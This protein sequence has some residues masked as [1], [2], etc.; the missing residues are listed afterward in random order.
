M[1]LITTLQTD[2]LALEKSDFVKGAI[3]AVLV[4][5]GTGLAP[6][7]QSG[8]FPTWPQDLNALYAGLTAGGM[9]L[10]KNLLTDAQGKF[11]GINTVTPVATVLPPAPPK[12]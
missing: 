1:T 11:L 2:F 12:V 6:I 8:A 7:L 9:Y 3:L 5:I 4:S 10:F